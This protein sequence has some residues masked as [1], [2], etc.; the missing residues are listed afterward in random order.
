M[1]VGS[2]LESKHSLQDVGGSYAESLE[3]EVPAEPPGADIV[4]QIWNHILYEM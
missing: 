4:V 3:D 1:P 2:M